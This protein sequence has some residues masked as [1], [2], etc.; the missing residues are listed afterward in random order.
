MLA[1]GLKVVAMNIFWTDLQSE[2]HLIPLPQ[3][4]ESFRLQKASS[5]G[6]FFDF[7][8]RIL[9]KYMQR[10][11]LKYMCMARYRFDPLITNPF[12]LY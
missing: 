7:E 10:I 1:T 3:E 2:Q 8:Q 4:N 6:D 12:P 5:P 9:L 11:L